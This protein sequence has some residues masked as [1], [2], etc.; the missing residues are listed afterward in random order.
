MS[1]PRILAIL[2]TLVGGWLFWGAFHAVEVIVSRGSGLAD[3]LLSP[4][5]SLMRLLGTG[6]LL[7]G[8]VLTI[9]GI[10]TGRWLVLTGTLL[11]C[12]LTGLMIASGADIALWQDEA[13]YSGV[14][15]LLTAGVLFTKSS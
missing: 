15:I 13:V 10:S 3:A 6:I 9:L 5:T 14:L 8:G 12:V 7:I 11:F 1:L 4:P 2:V